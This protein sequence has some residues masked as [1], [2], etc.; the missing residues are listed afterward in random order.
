ME[1]IINKINSNLNLQDYALDHDSCFLDIETTGLDR[2]RN[3]IYL[4]GI[5]YFESSS[6]SWTL[7][8]IFANNLEKE[9]EVLLKTVEILENYTSIINYNGTSFD[10]PFIN[11]KLEFYNIDYSI[12]EDRSFDIY[13]MIKSDRKFLNLENLKLKTIEKHLG[14]QREDTY[15]GKDCI[16]LYYDYISRGEEILKSN[17][18][19][20]NM[21]DLVYM[22][23]I[24]SILDIIKAN[25]SF[26]VEIE[27]I[28]LS[29]NFQIEGLNFENNFLMINGNIDKSFYKKI[30]YYDM[31]Y[32]LEIDKKDFLISIE[33]NKALISDD[34]LGQFIYMDDFIINSKH[35][36]L[37]LSV[38]KKLLIDNIKG[39]SKILIKK[40]I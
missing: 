2:I 34:K 22:L 33:T 4:I 26:L 40:S 39:L 37:V 35:K 23:D 16:D 30:I 19:R 32:S 6:N 29:Y 13:R 3:N 7:N 17:I 10:I 25:K 14:I 11:S 1:I 5:I 31:N 24:I 8:Q 18:L 20:H 9:R 27:E 21:D 38:D 12:H 28:D 36:A 15:S